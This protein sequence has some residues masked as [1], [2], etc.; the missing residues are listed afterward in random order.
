MY[1]AGMRCDHTGVCMRQ[2][3]EDTHTADRGT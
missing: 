2:E 3:Y 1:E